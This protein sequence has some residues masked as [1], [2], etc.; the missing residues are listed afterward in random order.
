MISTNLYTTSGKHQ[1]GAL[2]VMGD[3]SATASVDGTPVVR[4]GTHSTVSTLAQQ[5]A[6]AALRAEVR[7]KEMTRA[8]LGARGTAIVDQIVGDSYYANKTKHDAEVPNTNDPQLLARARQAT[9]F[10]NG[11]ARAS[12]PFKGMP[13]DQLALIA[14]DESGTFTVNERRAAWGESYDQEEVWRQLV[15][16]KADSE[17]G[18]TGK[19]T[20]FFTEVLAYYKDLPEIEQAQYPEGYE[21]K[22]Q[23]WIARDFNFKTGVGK[24]KSI[25]ELIQ[26]ILQNPQP[27]YRK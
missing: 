4:G 6:E 22:L 17:Y 12:N 1:F 24:E 7:N 21:M 10:I 2:R 8:E 23:G 13:R 26:E 16:R 20:K 5:L 11:K 25:A 15:V 9:D 19:L 14:Y 3:V 27:A 18:R